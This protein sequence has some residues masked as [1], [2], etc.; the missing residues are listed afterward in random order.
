MGVSIIHAYGAAPVHA[1][2][3][4]SVGVVVSCPCGEVYELRP[5]YAGRLLECPSC[6]RHLRAGPAATAPRPPT[7]GVD[8][9][10]D[11]DVFLLR[12]RVFT[13]TSKYEVWAEN[14]T[15]I[16]YVERPTY[17][18]R[19]LVAYLLAAIVTLSLTGWAAGAVAQDGS[20]LI[21]LLSVPVAAFIF[22]VIS[23]S[24]RP[25]R[26]VTIYRDDSRGETLL[27]V[28]QNQRVAFLTRTYTIVT[29]AGETLAILR[30]T[31]LHNIVRKRWYVTAPGGAPLA[32]A[33][34]DSIVLSLLRRVMGTFFGFLRTNFVF[35]RGADAE[36]FGE[37]NRKFTLLDRYVLD[38]SADPARTF[39]RRIAVA[40]GV[41][42][43]TGERR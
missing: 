43:D 21:I 4:A 37:F 8:H 9:A 19:T 26:H 36:I 17:P 12:E 2:S 31:Y 28:L 40:L 15:P 11:R 3:R 42:L 35:V 5:E 41:M 27:R 13:I 29:A 24:L 39:D 6:G 38:L 32:M 18:I 34:E 20:G 7:P 33:I 30:K 1:V 16:L 14:G 25:R 22:L 10:F 23:M